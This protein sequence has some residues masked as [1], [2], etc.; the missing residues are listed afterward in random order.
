MA[1][2]I[3]VEKGVSETTL[4]C[5]RRGTNGEKTDMLEK[6]SGGRFCLGEGL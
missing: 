2:A 3:K 4:G 5:Q 6:R 1:E